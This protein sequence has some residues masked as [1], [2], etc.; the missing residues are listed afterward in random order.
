MI[1]FLNRWRTGKE[2]FEQLSARQE[3]LRASL[4][5]KALESTGLES[6]QAESSQ[7]ESNRAAS[8]G[9]VVTTQQLSALP[10]PSQEATDGQDR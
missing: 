9:A 3:A 2:R 1:A 8:H 4:E 6:T 7:A 10:E 5:G